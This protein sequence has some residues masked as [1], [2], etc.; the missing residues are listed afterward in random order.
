MP[1]LPTP[2]EPR[3]FTGWHM[4]GIMVAF[5]G[6]VIGVNITLAVLSSGTWTGLVVE[7]SYVASQ[8]FQEKLDAL[9]VQQALGWS[10]SF[11][12]A[13]GNARLLVTDADGRPTDLG[14]RVELQ[15]NRPIGDHEDQTLM[16]ARATDGSYA[17]QTTLAGGAWDAVVLAP[18]TAA[19]PYELHRRIVVR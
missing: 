17:A 7:N 15:F 12:Y 9:H 18:D 3:P 5:F 14:P 11:A 1:A 16:L 13:D 10:S 2:I 6:V 4:L 8:E 19:G